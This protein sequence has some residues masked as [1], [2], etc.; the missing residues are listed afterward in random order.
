MYKEGKTMFHIKVLQFVLREHTPKAWLLQIQHTKTEGNTKRVPKQ[1]TTGFEKSDL[2]FN[3]A[4][5]SLQ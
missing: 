3:V 2:Q 5:Q 4:P 1:S